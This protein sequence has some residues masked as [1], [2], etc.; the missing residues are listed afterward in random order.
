MDDEKTCSIDSPQFEATPMTP[1][2]VRRVAAQ[3]RRQ[4]DGLAGVISS[5][6][7]MTVCDA[8]N[9]AEFD[10]LHLLR[11]GAINLAT[12]LE[13]TEDARR[14][15]ATVIEACVGNVPPQYLAAALEVLATGRLTDP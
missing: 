5:W 15:L 8:D 14:R 11:E 10:R 1:E 6:R 12:V 7:V 2:Q 9:A 4:P 3:I 13:A